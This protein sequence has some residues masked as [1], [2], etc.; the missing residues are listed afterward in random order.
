MCKIPAGRIGPASESPLPIPLG[1]EEA[2]SPQFGA[3]V[4]FV[5]QHQGLGQVPNRRDYVKDDGPRRSSRQSRDDG[6]RPESLGRSPSFFMTNPIRKNF[7]AYEGDYN[8]GLR[9]NRLFLDRIIR[10]S[11]HRNGRAGKSDP[12]VEFPRVFNFEQT[13]EPRPVTTP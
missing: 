12:V 3:L 10:V 13:S 5:N 6:R 1:D 4:V 11:T 8:G 7:I 9:F 2:C